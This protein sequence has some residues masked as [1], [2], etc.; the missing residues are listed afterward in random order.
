[1][2]LNE[3]YKEVNFLLSKNAEGNTMSPEQ[4]NVTIEAV[5]LE[6]YQSE[7]DK[8]HAMMEGKPS[9]DIFS[10]LNQMTALKPFLKEYEIPESSVTSGLVSLPSNYDYFVGMMY[11]KGNKTPGDELQPVDLV[12][13]RES[14]TR[15][16][17]LADHPPSERPFC[18]LLENDKL[19]CYPKSL[20]DDGDLILYYYRMPVQPVFDY[21]ISNVTGQVIHLPIGY[22]IW[23]VGG[24]YKVY[25]A[26]ANVI[27]E[28][29]EYPAGTGA[30]YTTSDTIELEWSRSFHWRFILRILEK[31]G[32]NI[33][34][35]AVVQYV[36]MQ[37]S[38]GK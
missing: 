29:C 30:T 32:V 23:Y 31:A 8:L 18:V 28:D 15:R 37:K 22:S 27:A 16:S 11:H 20:G 5:N 33:R 25:D 9:N 38:K 6:F 34:D 21:A 10:V 24:T 12:T 1:M 19:Q 3:I 7:I 4:F 35:S 26:G 17:N 2:T 36:E 13:V 14:L